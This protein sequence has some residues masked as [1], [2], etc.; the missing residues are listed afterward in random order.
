MELPKLRLWA[1]M[2]ANGVHESTEERPN[3]P[4]ITDKMPKHARRESMHDVIMGA[5]KGVAQAFTSP[6]HALI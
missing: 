4:M 2:I 1:R 3:L 6:T 5:A